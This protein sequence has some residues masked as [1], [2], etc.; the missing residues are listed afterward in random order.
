MQDPKIPEKAASE[1]PWQLA[2]AAPEMLKSLRDLVESA[3]DVPNASIQLVND[4]EV[5]RHAIALAEGRKA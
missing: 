4:I 2:A 5:A 1:A 3:S